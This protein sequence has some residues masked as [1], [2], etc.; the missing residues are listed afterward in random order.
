MIE[1]LKD[2]VQGDI[3]R[4]PNNE[5]VILKVNEIIGFLNSQTTVT[6]EL[7][8]EIKTLKSKIRKNKPHDPYGYEAY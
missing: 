4:K 3:A 8:K 6:K 7:K 1:K 5:E 2:I